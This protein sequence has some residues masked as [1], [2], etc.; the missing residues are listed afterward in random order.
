MKTQFPFFGYGTAL[1][2]LPPESAPVRISIINPSP[3]PLYA[4]APPIGKIAPGGLPYSVFGSVVGRPS[5]SISH[6]SGHCWPAIF[7][8]RT[9]PSAVA[10]VE[11]SSTSGVSPLGTPIASGLVERRGAFP[12]GWRRQALPLLW[13]FLRLERAEP[14][15][16]QEQKVVSWA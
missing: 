2:Q 6:P 13:L 9:F 3:K 15:T 11:K 5:L 12:P 1:A 7:F 16:I 8:T 10:L 14:Q 4:C